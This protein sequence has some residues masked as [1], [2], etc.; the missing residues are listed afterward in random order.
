MLISLRC[1]FGFAECRAD[2]GKVTTCHPRAHDFGLERREAVDGAVDQGARFGGNRLLFHL[3][4][5]HQRGKP[6][7]NIVQR[8]DLAAIPRSVMVNEQVASD[9]I[10]PAAQMRARAIAAVHCLNR[11]EYS[12]AGQIV[13]GAGIAYAPVEKS[14]KRI[15]ILL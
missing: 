11:F 8:N 7:S 2:L 14:I 5:C 9:T 3:P 1:A 10:E 15:A 13:G 6:G 12:F 4:V